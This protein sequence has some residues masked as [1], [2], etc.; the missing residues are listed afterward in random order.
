MTK[1]IVTFTL[2]LAMVMALTACGT[3]GP[4]LPTPSVDPS[5]EPTSSVDPS[6]EPTSSVDPSGE[7]T[8]PTDPVDES[9][10]PIIGAKP[11]NAVTLISDEHIAYIKGIG[12]GLFSPDSYITRGEAAVILCRLLSDTVPVTVSYTDVP[13]N[14]WYTEAAEQLGSLGV[15]RPNEN[16]FHSEEIISRGEFVSY[17]ASFFPV[18][19]DAEQFPDVRPDHSYG[20]AILSGRAWGWLMGLP[21][22]NFGPEDVI[23]RS[24]AVA[25]INRALGRTGDQADIAANRPA[26][27]LDVPVS[28]WYYNDVMEATVPHTFT[29]NE[30]DAETWTSFTPTD[31]GLPADF[32]TEGFHLH[33]G[34]CY[35]YSA[36][37]EDILR[38]CTVSGYTYDADG[39]FTTGDAWVDQQLRE[40][41][42]SQ[43]TPGVTREKMLERFFAYCR[44]NYKYLKWN[45]Y[46]T[47]DTS[48]TLDAARQ[49]L[50]TGRGNC[51]CY[52]SVFWYLARWIGYD[53]RIFSGTVYGDYHSWVEIDGYIYDPQLEWRF[54]HDRGNTWYLW[55]FYHLLDSS[56]SHLY[57]K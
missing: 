6:G 2:A 8:R 49:M 27:F 53:A 38:S 56:D 4:D 23:H 1:R 11:S 51:Y 44:D 18:R 41:V 3:L 21:D 35:Y 39:H 40:I 5:D 19:T 10:S 32:L 25:I 57:R 28:E 26:F 15:I 7:P 43:I 17:I 12:S 37:A 42:L 54:V 45:L 34:W 30:A 33:Q 14:S 29:V 9:P 13:E 55:H 47:G 20:D 52:A 22:G 16:T 48:F 31:T 36:D 24:E 46:E 50:S